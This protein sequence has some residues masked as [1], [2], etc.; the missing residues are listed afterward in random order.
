[1]G[2]EWA[3]QPRPPSLPLHRISLPTLLRLQD[4]P[5]T[6]LEKQTLA[7]QGSAG[8]RD[9]KALSHLTS[10]PFAISQCWFIA[11]SS[12]KRGYYPVL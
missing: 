7:A 4:C 11:D 1:M 6:A 3:L 9:H 12:A 8:L 5:P 2:Q 10:I